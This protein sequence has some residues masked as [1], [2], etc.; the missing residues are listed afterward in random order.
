MR[1]L[2]A[3]VLPIPISPVPTQSGAA[4]STRL[5]P[6][7]M[8]TPASSRL[9]AGPFARLAVP[10]ATLRPATCGRP[11]RSAATPR[12]ATT[13]VARTWRARTLTAAPSAAKFATIWAVTAWG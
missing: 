3:V 7:A 6:A 4:S 9:M 2:A 11:P 10:G 12:S 1:A 5:A 13:T 8:A